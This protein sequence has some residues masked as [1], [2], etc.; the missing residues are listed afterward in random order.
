MAEGNGLLNRHSV[1]ER[2]RGFESLPLRIND[3]QALPIL[4]G[5]FRLMERSE[6]T[7]RTIVTNRKALHDFEIVQRFEAGIVLTGTE[8]KSVRAG[9]VSITDSYAYFPN[10]GDNELILV[11]LHINPYEF[12]SVENHEPTRRRKLLLHDHELKRLRSNVDE[13]G[14]TI[15]PL[16]LY[17]SGPFIKVELGMVRGK[18]QYDK[19]AA[20]KDKELKREARRAES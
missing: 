12:G 20:L 5:F 2:Y 17:F 14:L 15:V 1:F 11:G 13:K 8:V 7:I 18:R 16:S 10:K 3:L 19:R 9:K 6:R 4:Q